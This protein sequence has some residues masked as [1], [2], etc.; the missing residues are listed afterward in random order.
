MRCD[1]SINLWTFFSTGLSTLRTPSRQPMP[2]SKRPTWTTHPLSN[3]LQPPPP[4]KMCL[5]HTMTFPLLPRSHTRYMT[6][7]LRRHIRSH[8]LLF[9]KWFPRPRL[10]LRFGTRQRS[11][12]SGRCGQARG[13]C[14]RRCGSYVPGYLAM[15]PR[16]ILAQVY[17]AVDRAGSGGA[18]GGK[19]SS[20]C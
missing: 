11:C 3:H 19:W 12:V 13:R 2:P 4:F 6:H 7:R 14:G 5:P 18:R 8:F 17:C 1:S 15:V 10:S 9:Y 16:P 20:G